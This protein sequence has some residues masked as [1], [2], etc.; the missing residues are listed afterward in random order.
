MSIVHRLVARVLPDISRP[1]FSAPVSTA[2]DDVS[3]LP[4]TISGPGRAATL[5]NG[6]LF[7]S[8]L[9]V[10][11]GAIS[12][13][14][15]FPEISG[16]SRK[17][18][19]V[20]DHRA[21]YDVL[22]VGSSRFHHGIVPPQFDARIAEITGQRIR[23]FNFGHD[24]MWPPESFFILRKLLALR[25]PHLRW[26]FID[27]VAI[28]TQ[29]DPRNMLTKRTAYW[30]DARHTALAWRALAVEAI[31][32]SDRVRRAV[33]HGTLLLRNWTN[34][35]AGAEWLAVEFGVV[36]RKKSARGAPAWKSSE[37]E[38]YEPEPDTPMT[39]EKLAEFQSAVAD[40]RENLPPQPIDRVFR[41][42][43][44]D[45]IAEVRA[46]GAQPVLLLTPTVK[47]KENFTGLPDGVPVLRFQDPNAFPQF[48]DPANCYDNE[49]LNHAGAQLFTAELARRFAEL[50]PPKP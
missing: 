13:A 33:A 35:G 25:P 20:A 34:A 31:P 38:G 3:A 40:F 16:I 6:A 47:E 11:C 30:H 43:L 4:T 29:I 49:H 28:R 2:A 7:F 5:R 9:A 45:A 42:A 15:P 1:L 18:R 12:A 22:F 46:A 41:R 39:A 48:F 24:A 10:V 19:H 27:C 21:D 17:Y 14:R 23:S 50:L 26:V 37:S 44:D 8:A 32:W 36:K